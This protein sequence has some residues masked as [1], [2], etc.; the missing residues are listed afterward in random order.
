MENHQTETE[1]LEQR[2]AAMEQTLA[3]QNQLLEQQ[4]HRDK[5]RRIW[6]LVKLGV[7]VVLAVIWIPRGLGF[8]QEMQE[9]VDQSEE[10]LMTM[11]QQTDDFLADAETK[12]DMAEDVM[13]SLQNIL[14]PLEDLAT[15]WKSLW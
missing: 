5:Q 1:Q 8:V 4:A 6:S 15:K 10:Q 14:E 7:V 3:Y 9:F 12:L 2:I 11:Q 13:G